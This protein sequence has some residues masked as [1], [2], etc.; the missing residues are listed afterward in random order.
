MTHPFHSIYTHKFIRVAVCTPFVRVADPQ[1][2]LERT[3]GLARRASELKAAVALFPELGISAYSNEDLFHQDALLDAVEAALARLI[4]ESR[5]LCPVLM[6][7]APLRFEGKLFNCAVT[8]YRGRLLGITPKTYLPNYREFYE[9]RQFTSGRNAVGR[10]MLFLGE[11]I[12]F[13]N[14]LIFEATNVE[15]FALHVEI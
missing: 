11:A 7:G 3:L 6:V 10:E 1:F 15:D 5:E 13:G 14:D 4:T 2:N 8:V 9:K 12:P